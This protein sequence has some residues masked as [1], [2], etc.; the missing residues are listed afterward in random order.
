MGSGSLPPHRAWASALLLAVI[1][2]VI[3]FVFGPG[4]S[5]AIAASGPSSLNTVFTSWQT[6]YLYT[7]YTFLTT[8][9]DVP[10]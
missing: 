1:V 3:L 4:E 7:R 9:R 8:A 6:A 5:Q 10:L 2:A